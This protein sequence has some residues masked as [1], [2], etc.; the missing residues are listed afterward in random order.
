MLREFELSQMISSMSNY[1]IT[2]RIPNQSKVLLFLGVFWMIELNHIDINLNT[3][4]CIHKTFAASFNRLKTF[5]KHSNL[6]NIMTLIDYICFTTYL[7][8][9]ALALSKHVIMRK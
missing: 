9:T 5:F 1:F 8:T 6:P 3:Y 4:K 7:L 2:P